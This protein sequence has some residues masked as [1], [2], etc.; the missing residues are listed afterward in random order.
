MC[1]ADYYAPSPKRTRP[2]FHT[3]SRRPAGMGDSPRSPAFHR[4]GGS[5]LKATGI[6]R[7]IDDLGR[8]VIPKP[9][10]RT[11]CSRIGEQVELFVAQNGGVVLQK[12]SPVAALGG[13]V[14]RVADA[15]R[16][17]TGHVALVTDATT[18]LA[19][20]VG[21]EL[22]GQPVGP[23]I[24]AAVARGQP[25]LSRPGEDADERAL[26]GV[27]DPARS[28]RQD[29]FLDHRGCAALADLLRLRTFRF[30]HGRLR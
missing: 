20:T 14:P 15:L 5:L 4:E 24:D 7:R 18:V 12:Y 21:P 6:V 19:A 2:R 3:A 22:L 11:L 27:Y 28:A 25:S 9:L 23:A 26:L 8:V 16:D 13:M 10:R 1:A 17:A 30:R 29:L